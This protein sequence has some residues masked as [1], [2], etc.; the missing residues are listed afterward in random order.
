MDR[1]IL[2]AIERLG[3]TLAAMGVSVKR[4]VVFGSAARGHRH[5]DS[6]IDIAAI[7]DDFGKMNLYERLTTCGR[8]LV[9]ANISPPFEV[10]PFTEREYN[11]ALPG[12]FLNDEVKCQGIEVA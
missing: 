1:E 4:F 12:S 8:A 9:V 5:A 3:K 6:D 10:L 11:N 2:E 7:S